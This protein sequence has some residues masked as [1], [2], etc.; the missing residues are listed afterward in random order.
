MSGV[1][2]LLPLSIVPSCIVFVYSKVTGKD[3]AF[4][5]KQTDLIQSYIYFG[6]PAVYRLYAIKPIHR[7]IHPVGFDQMTTGHQSS[8]GL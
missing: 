1:K 3:E 5:H 4:Q 8:Q 6:N 7:Y 2:V